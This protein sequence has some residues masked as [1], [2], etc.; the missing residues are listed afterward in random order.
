MTMEYSLF[1]YIP[2]F[3]ALYVLTTHFFHRIRNLPP[4]PLLSLPIIGHLYLL[5]KPLHQ[6]FT[7]ISDRYGPIFFLQLGSRPLIVV[8]SPSLAEECLTKNDIVFANRPNM[9]MGRILGYNNTSLAWASYGDHWRNLRRISSLE[10]LSTHRLHLLSDIRRDEVKLLIKRLVSNQKRQD[11]QS[12]DARLTF[13]KLTL[14]IMMRM[15]AGKRYY[16]NDEADLEELKR[17]REFQSE[18]IRIARKSNLA[19]YLPI[20]RFFGGSRALERD[21]EEVHRKRDQFMQTLIEEHKRKMEIDPNHR[22]GS[23]RKME[24]DPNHR[25]GSN[26]KTLIEVLLS[27]QKTEPEYYKD[28]LIRS[29]MLVRLGFNFN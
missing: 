5:K 29:L 13:V 16:D 7:K 14:N 6:T 20:I 25:F 27:L 2:A 10:I 23:N 17:F 8:S 19:D 11:F 12:L 22:F 15:I 21:M 9:A 26:R 1:L 24:I 28:D 18:I 3:L 4:S